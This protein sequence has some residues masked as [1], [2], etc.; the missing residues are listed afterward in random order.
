MDEPNELLLSSSTLNAWSRR[1][2]CSGGPIGACSKSDSWLLNPRGLQ[3]VTVPYGMKVLREAAT[4]HEKYWYGSAVTTAKCKRDSFGNRA[5]EYPVNRDSGWKEKSFSRIEDSEFRRL[6]LNPPYIIY[7]KY[8]DG[9]LGKRSNREV[10]KS[11]PAG[12]GKR[13]KL[14][15]PAETEAEAPR[16]SDRG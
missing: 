10:V 11:S 9:G 14:P 8:I 12:E 15:A 16:R 13:D 2:E 7:N 1:I 4:K 6:D 3:A 5:A